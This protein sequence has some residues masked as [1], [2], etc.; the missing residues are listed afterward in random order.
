M[1]IYNL[2]NSAVNR[3]SVFSCYDK[4]KVVRIAKSP[5][6]NKRFHVGF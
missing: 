6:F 4:A 2:S 1:L 3:Y 5:S